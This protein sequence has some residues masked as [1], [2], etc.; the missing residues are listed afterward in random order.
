MMH[1][2]DTPGLDVDIDENLAAHHPYE[3][4]FRPVNLL[5]DGTMFNW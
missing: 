2:G 4:A 3:R 1:P 5:E